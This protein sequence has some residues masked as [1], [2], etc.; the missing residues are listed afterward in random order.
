MS[1]EDT[2]ADVIVVGAGV[3]GLQAALTLGRACRSVFVFDDGH[4]RNA[5]AAQVN[6]YLPI[7]DVSPSQFAEAGSTMLEPYRISRVPSRVTAAAGDGL[8]G[9]VVEAGGQSYRSRAIILAGGL[10]DH[11][12]SIPG[13]ID[14]WGTKVVACPHCHGWEVR[15]QPLAQVTFSDD[16]GLGTARAV[17]LSRWSDR[18]TFFRNGAELPTDQSERLARAGVSVRPGPVAEISDDGRSGVMVRVGIEEVGGFA[19]VFSTVRQ[20]QQ[21][22]LP[23]VLGCALADDGGSGGAILTDSA[24]RSSVPGVW[25]AGSS[26]VPSLLAVGAAGHASVVATAVHADLTERDLQESS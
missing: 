20:T 19:T 11:L 25:A 5:A 18:V 3:A 15:G 9:F 23:M 10:E 7:R 14:L 22:P 12:P 16:A 4:P 2:K 6:N 21:S 13:L 24:G 8:T 26:T 17:L 1:H